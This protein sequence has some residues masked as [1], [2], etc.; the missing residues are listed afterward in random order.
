MTLRTV[1]IILFTADVSVMADRDQ[2][3]AFPDVHVTVVPFELEDIRAI[4]A[5]VARRIVATRGTVMPARQMALATPVPSLGED[6]LLSVCPHGYD[7][8]EWQSASGG[9]A[10]CS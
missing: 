2:L 10:R 8:G 1:P 5:S 9:C 6:R 3:A 4:V 7:E